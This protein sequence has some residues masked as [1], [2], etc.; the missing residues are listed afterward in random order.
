MARVIFHVDLDAFYASVE[1]RSNPSYRGK[2]LIIGADPKEGK[3]RGVVVTCSYEA[4]KFGVRSA[5]P[6][7]IAYRL[8]PGG[9]YIRPNFDLYG[10]VSA[11]VMALLKEYADKF[12]QASIDEAYLD[13]TNTCS[14]FGGPIGLAKKIKSELAN[15]E[16]LTCSIGVAPNKSAAKIASDIQKPDGLTYIDAAHVREFLAPLPVSKISGI[17]KKTEQRLGELQVKTIG[18][19]AKYSPTALYEEFG[20]NA[21]W[22]LAI[23]NAEERVEVQENYVIK[24]LG[25]EETFDEDTEDWAT[26]EKHLISLSE[27]IHERLVSDHMVFKT[28]TLKIRFTG[29]ETYTR[30]KTFRFASASK[31]TII[32]GILNLSTEFKSSGKK[33]RLIGVRVSS[34]E[35]K[36][37]KTI[38]EFPH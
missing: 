22:L 17:G 34:L 19:L 27:S 20:K 37:A 26:I 4:R 35:K 6:I 9:I 10:E 11:D 7:S 1:V 24:S 23:A 14:S 38:D 33:V 29:F 13:V 15:R 32:D 28:V 3:G 36:Q 25:T 31:Q 21:V 5:Q 2:P 18:D 8:C 30:S 12:E 16:G